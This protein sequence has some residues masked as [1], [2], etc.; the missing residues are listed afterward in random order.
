VSTISLPKTLYKTYSEVSETEL[1]VI[2]TGCRRVLGANYISYSVWSN[3]PEDVFNDRYWGQAVSKLKILNP[4]LK[5]DKALILGLGGGTLAY[6]LHKYFTPKKIVG[7]ELDPTV[8]NIG[9]NYFY[10]NLIK[11]LEIIQ[12]D[13]VKWIQSKS[14]EKITEKEKYDV[15]FMD[16]FKVEAT[17]VTCED[18]DF[19]A[20]SSKLLKHGG[21][22]SLNKI[23]HREDKEEQIKDY[24][25]KKIKPYFQKITYD[26]YQKALGL[27]NVLIYA[28]K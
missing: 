1:F 25:G 8:I 28:I 2:E 27:D 23:F 24:L 11:N 19:F 10:L 22:L 14:G 9:K 6:L 12:T 5:I 18:T 16:I 21:I 26:R 4:K 3:D 20:K 13:A 17:P 7:I 15:I